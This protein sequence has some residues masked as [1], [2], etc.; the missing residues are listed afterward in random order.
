MLLVDS[1]DDEVSRH[2]LSVLVLLASSPH[3]AACVG[4]SD[5]IT[6]SLAHMGSSR[7]HIRSLDMLAIM[8]LLSKEAVNRIKLREAGALSAIL[9]ALN[10]DK[11]A[12]VHDRIISS[13]LN[14]VHD[15]ASLSVMI[16]SDLVPTLMHHLQRCGHF[17]SNPVFH[18]GKLN[19]QVTPI[20]ENVHTTQSPGIPHQKTK[21]HDQTKIP[22]EN[23]L[24]TLYPSRGADGSDVIFVNASECPK[25]I[26]EL[27]GLCLGISLNQS[28]V[29]F[30]PTC[31]HLTN[32][33]NLNGTLS[34]PTSGG[35]DFNMSVMNAEDVNGRLCGADGHTGERCAPLDCEW[36][37]LWSDS[38]QSCGTRRP[39]KSGGDYL[40]TD[41]KSHNSCFCPISSSG[42]DT[43][44]PQASSE[45]SLPSFPFSPLSVTS[46]IS[47]P[48]F[49]QFSPSHSSPSRSSS[50][51][52]CSPHCAATES[53]YIGSPCSSM[54][55]SSVCSPYGTCTDRMV[56]YD[57]HDD[58]TLIFSSSDDDEEN[59]EEVELDCECVSN[60]SFERLSGS[61]NAS[62]KSSSTVLCYAR[63]GCAQGD[64]K[65]PGIQPPLS[66]F[67]PS[68]CG[69]LSKCDS[70][71]PE[72][73]VYCDVS[74]EART[75]CDFSPPSKRR[76]FNEVFFPPN[77]FLVLFHNAG[78]TVSPVGESCVKTVGSDGHSSPHEIV[79]QDNILMLLS[80]LSVNEDFMAH[81]TS[82]MSIGTLF[83]H[84]VFAVDP[85]PRCLRIL[86]RLLTNPQFFD[87]WLAMCLPA[88][89]FHKFLVN[90]E[91]VITNPDPELLSHMGPPGSSLCSPYMLSEFGP[92]VGQSSIIAASPPANDTVSTVVQPKTDFPD[93][94]SP[95]YVSNS[96]SHRSPR[97]TGAQSNAQSAFPV[98]TRSRF[99]ATRTGWCLLKDIA[100]QAMT[101]YGE[102]VVVNSVRCPRHHA[103]HVSTLASVLFF[104]PHWY[105]FIDGLHFAGH[106]VFCDVVLLFVVS[107]QSADIQL[108]SIV[109]L[110]ACRCPD[111][112]PTVST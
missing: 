33:V 74:S 11:M 5:G 88:T 92:C 49:P 35:S 29:V 13:L 111:Y 20:C 68:K 37:M 50:Y 65:A 2:S 100:E 83:D 15:H 7:R 110:M 93:R 63:E 101:T 85:Q 77:Y 46:Y 40:A 8:C 107:G 86:S 39:W 54:P 1:D 28:A 102:Q 19:F 69:L 43:L 34:G 76:K 56:A 18:F 71:M 44:S 105:V 75:E 41:C 73:Q 31:G 51:S 64:I 14:F 66:A 52:A 9:S 32:N 99:D 70:R 17:N 16:A 3:G 62:H 67:S 108:K 45:A 24:S 72:D 60:E 61:V 109:G 91:G 30:T 57:N 58:S 87:N 22:L 82:T 6:F 112:V 59:S 48:Y 84:L 38:S 12:D 104:L 4:A 36:S 47:P 55:Y 25:T 21:P 81:L 27:N 106:L 42:G 95:L 23:D 97:E 94:C 79:T 53:D 103:A 96:R 90:S 89:I 98:E 10:D 80:Q 78:L 26:E